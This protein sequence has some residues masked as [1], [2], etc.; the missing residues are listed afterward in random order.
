MH[1]EGILA[2]QSDRIAVLS[3]K[4]SQAQCICQLLQISQESPKGQT[5]GH[6]LATHNEVVQP[7]SKTRK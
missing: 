2:G 5:A 6:D 4:V 3:W 1:G 7:A